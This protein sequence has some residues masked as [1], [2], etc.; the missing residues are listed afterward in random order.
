MAGRAAYVL[1]L[2]ATAAVSGCGTLDNIK[3]P[4]TPPPAN[5]NAPVCRV[6][7]GVIGEVQVMSEFKKESISSPLDYVVIPLLGTIDLALTV[8]GDTVTL[9]YTI[10]AE[11]R[12][13]MR[14]SEPA[15]APT[16]G[17]DPV[18]DPVPP[19]TSEPLPPPANP[20]VTSN[21]T[22]RAK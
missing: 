21:L 3:R 1:G 14:R 5:P 8:G 12:R 16:G 2:V 22:P 7:G 20:P 10:Y 15:P 11:V 4:I 13:L 17:P 18:P 9:P 6:Y 19:P